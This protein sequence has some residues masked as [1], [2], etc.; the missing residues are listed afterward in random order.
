VR[1]P[2]GEKS[3]FRT[4]NASELAET[5]DGR[6]HM[7]LDID[8]NAPGDQWGPMVVPEGHFL[9]MGD[10]RDNSDD[11]RFPDMGFVSF[12]RLIGRAE[13]VIFAPRGCAPTP[14]VSCFR[15]RFLKPLA[16]DVGRVGA[17]S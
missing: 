11:G 5:I 13:T 9:F 16:R 12:E 6:E 7:V 15:S 10:N 3:L 1:L 17:D 4:Y 14:E 2:T 8:P